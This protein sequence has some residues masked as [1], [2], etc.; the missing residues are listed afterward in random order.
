MG[1]GAGA[2]AEEVAAVLSDD[3]FLPGRFKCEFCDH[4]CEDKKLLLN[5]QLL[6]INDRPYRCSLCSYATIREDFLLSHVAV[7]HTGEGAKGGQREVL[8]GSL[9]AAAGREG[10]GG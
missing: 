1:V 2:G 5:H 3:R 6:H 4:V 9:G 7:K 10:A 8:P